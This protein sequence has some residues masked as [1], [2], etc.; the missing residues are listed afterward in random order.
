M[1]LI[2]LE[3][4]KGL[5]VGIANE[6][7]VAY[8]CARQITE[9]GAEVVVT[10]QNEKAK[11]FV[12]PAVNQ[13]DHVQALLPYDTTQEGQLE[14]VFEWIK[15]NWG[16][17][18]FIIHS[19]AFARE[20]QSPIIDNTAEGFAQA[21]DISCY[22]FIK[23]AKLG[24][25]LMTNGGVMLTMTY[26]GSEK[27]IENYNVMGPVKAALESTSRYLAKDLGPKNIRVFCISPGPIQTRAASGIKGFDKLTQQ[28][29]DK[30]PLKDS[31][32]GSIPK[33]SDKSIIAS[34]A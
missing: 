19:M 17:L 7:S 21:M 6:L 12:E 26:Y 5:V 18:D 23:M 22:S 31:S 15:T 20:I 30:S 25:P 3:G 34:L 1:S 33:T 11:R 2:N 4:K 28:A 13:L 8:G 24:E 16:Q 9:A 27:V 10:Y 32:F 29:I 14:A